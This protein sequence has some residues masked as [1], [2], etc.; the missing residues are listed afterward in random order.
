M[1]AAGTTLEHVINLFIRPAAQDSPV[2]HKTTAARQGFHL[3][4]WSKA[5]MT[6]WVI[7]DLNDTGCKNLYD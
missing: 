2:E 5:G 4:Q 3:V 6:Y 1:A 7:S